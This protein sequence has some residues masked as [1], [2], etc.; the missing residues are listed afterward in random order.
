MNIGFKG[1]FVVTDGMTPALKAKLEEKD[2]QVIDTTAFNR[3]KKITEGNKYAVT[4]TGGYTGFYKGSDFYN[5]TSKLKL[6]GQDNETKN[7]AKAFTNII[8]SYEKNAII[9]QTGKDAVQKSPWKETQEIQQ[10]PF[11]FYTSQELVEE[12]DEDPKIL[13]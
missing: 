9:I 13:D 12:I 7:D 2:H 1:N 10:N 5:F 8:H 3:L 6:N 4:T 11:N